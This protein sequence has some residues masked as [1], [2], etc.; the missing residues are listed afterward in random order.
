MVVEANGLERSQLRSTN[1]CR[2][3]PPS[4]L[5][6]P[7][8]E[9]GNSITGR[10]GLGHLPTE[11]IQR[12]V[13]FLDSDQGPSSQKLCREPSSSLVAS[14]HRPL[15][16]LSLTCHSLR[17]LVISSL[18]R[19]TSIEIVVDDFLSRATLKNF[20][21]FAAKNR[22]RIR[23]VATWFVLQGSSPEFSHF[24]FAAGICSGI[25]HALEPVT[26]TIIAPPI[27]LPQLSFHSHRSVRPVDDW[28]FDA[29][30]HVLNY[31]RTSTEQ[32]RAKRDHVALRS[33]GWESSWSST[34]LNEGSSIK[35]YGS[36]EYYLKTAP[37]VFTYS[38]FSGP[39]P[40]SDSLRSFTY[41]AVFPTST[42]VRKIYENIGSL[43]NLQDLSVQF[44]PTEESSILSDPERIGKCQISD[45]WMEFHECLLR[46]LRFAS[47]QSSVH[48]LTTLTF[49]D[50]CRYDTATSIMPDLVNYLRDWTSENDGCW[51]K[52]E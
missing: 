51:K 16:C 17:Y 50:W 46:T 3:S 48:K 29:P 24:S 5:A 35:V 22:L 8:L 44:A 4:P 34:T 21:D 10:I 33:G 25:V 19:F 47:A 28:A 23:S 49:L 7:N 1:A 20:L 32:A 26:L 41:I 31:S 13:F 52:P 14:E 18:F 42:H 9:I 40:W 43:H 6:G 39:M 30:L 37:S 45:C 12:I 15:K 38:P 11:L 2:S 27:V 36:Y